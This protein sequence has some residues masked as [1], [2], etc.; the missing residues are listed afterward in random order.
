MI[1]D[2]KSKIY[3]LIPTVGDATPRQASA[4]AAALGEEEGGGAPVRTIQVTPQDKQAI[5]RVLKP[6]F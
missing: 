6:F 2:R 5:D 3:F 4:A 1:I